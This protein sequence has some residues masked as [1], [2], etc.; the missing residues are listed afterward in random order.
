ML[1]PLGAHYVPTGGGHV[2]KYATSLHGVVLLIHPCTS[3]T[4][5]SQSLLP[6]SLF[7]VVS[8]YFLEPCV[9]TIKESECSKSCGG[10]TK[11]LTPII[12]RHARYGGTPCPSKRT[13]PCNEH[14]CPEGETKKEN[15]IQRTH[16]LS[17][18]YA[19]IPWGD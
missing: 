6:L 17:L 2:L 3:Y 19:C 4:Q 10:G 1:F 8:D 7:M 12:S 13:V 15:S 14:K 9:F 18:P 5:Q 11:S 16:T